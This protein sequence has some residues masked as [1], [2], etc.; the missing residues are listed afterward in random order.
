VNVLQPHA[1]KVR[2]WF[3]LWWHSSTSTSIIYLENPYR[4]FRWLSA[5]SFSF[6]TSFLKLRRAGPPVTRHAKIHCTLTL[7]CTLCFFN[8]GTI[9]N[10]FSSICANGGKLMTTSWKNGLIC[11]RRKGSTGVNGFGVRNIQYIRIIR[12][13]MRTWVESSSYLSTL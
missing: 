1:T 4:S 9:I 5:N 13:V 3:M 12:P 10:W 11:L 8:S 6:R 2:Q 7:P